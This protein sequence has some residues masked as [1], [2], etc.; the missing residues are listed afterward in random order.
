MLRLAPWASRPGTPTARATG[1]PSLRELAAR[2]ADTAPA[3][4]EARAQAQAR[5][6]LTL[7]LAARA[8]ALAE[9]WTTSFLYD[10]AR[11]P[12]GHRLQRRRTAP[13]PGLLRP[14]GVGGRGW[15]ASSPSPRARCRSRAGSR[16]GRLLTTAGGDAGAAVV[17]RLDVRVPDA[18]AGDAELRAH[19]ARPDRARRGASARSST[20][21]SAACPGASRSRATTPPT[22]R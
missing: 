7:D 4:I 21:A 2:T 15:A 3:D 22:R 20:A 11:T 8:G 14:A 5:L 1:L 9:R 16:S 13:R 19:A 6:A 12:D 10:T 17:E 18:D